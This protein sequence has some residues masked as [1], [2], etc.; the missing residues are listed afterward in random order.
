[1]WNFCRNV[2]TF[3]FF[4]P[5]VLEEHTNQQPNITWKLYLESF[6]KILSIFMDEV[7]IFYC[8]IYQLL[9]LFMIHW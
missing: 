6:V 7:Q 3:L 4:Y 5:P 8:L 9:A 1:M 2:K